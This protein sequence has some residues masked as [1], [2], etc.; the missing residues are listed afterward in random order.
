MRPAVDIT[1]LTPLE[2]E[3]VELVGRGFRDW[4]I[5]ETFWM[6][7]QTLNVHLHSIFEKLG[8][9][10]QTELAQ[11]AACLIPLPARR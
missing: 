6:T 7:R 2:R 5:D 11:L 4:Q 10:D 8:V 1:R 3:I 9:A